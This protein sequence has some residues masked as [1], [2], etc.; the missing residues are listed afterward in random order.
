MS[1]IEGFFECPDFFEL[2]VD[3]N[4]KNKKWVLSAA[5]SGY[6]VGTFDGTTFK[7][8][9]P[10]LRGNWGSGFYAPQT[11]SDLPAKDGRRIRIGWF[12][13]DSPNMAFNQSMSIPLELKLVSTADGPRMTSTPVE[14][15]KVL[16]GKAHSINALT[17]KP[18]DANPLADIH[19]DELEIRVKITPGEAKQFSLNV[20]GASLVYDAATQEVVLNG[21]RAKAPLHN[22]SQELAIYLDR[23]TLEV[24]A[25]GGLVYMP[26]PFIPKAENTSLEVSAKGGEVKIE[27]LEV[28]PLNSAWK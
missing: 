9:T 8:G 19:G 16:R 21:Q 15:L 1:K 25:D 22:G 12:R 4:A 20:R 23:T 13:A 5:N 28:Y 26:Q 6:M 17:L 14:E 10:L 2:P 11:F 7:P 27:S 18:G 24:F 3:G